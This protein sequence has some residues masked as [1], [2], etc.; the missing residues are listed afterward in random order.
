MDI[1]EIKA[2]FNNRSTPPLRHHPHTQQTNQLPF[3]R[4]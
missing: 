3:P 2:T 1:K 4:G